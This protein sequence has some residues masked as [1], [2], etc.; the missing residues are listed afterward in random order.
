M[1]T[2]ANVIKTLSRFPDNFSVDDLVDKM[3]LLDKIERGIQDADDG[4]VIS[5]EEL[6][7]RMEEWSK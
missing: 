6:D 3:I 7:K 5:E 1:L 2:K 4:K